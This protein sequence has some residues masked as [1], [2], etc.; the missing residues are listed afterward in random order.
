MEK[1]DIINALYTFAHKRPGLEPRNYISDWR[2]VEGRRAY[3]SESR[4][5]TRDLQHARVLLRQVELSSISAEIIGKRSSQCI[6]WQIN[7]KPK[8]QRSNSY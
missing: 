3:N 6:L 7:N 4:A 5:I 1:Q 2:D 8:R